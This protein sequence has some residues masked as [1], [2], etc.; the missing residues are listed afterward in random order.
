LDTGIH[1]QLSI[2]SSIDWCLECDPC[3][4]YGWNY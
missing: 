4:G 1:A 2:Y 3:E